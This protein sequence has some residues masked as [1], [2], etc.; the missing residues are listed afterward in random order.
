MAITGK[1]HHTMNSNFRSF[2]IELKTHRVLRVWIAFYGIVVCAFFRV[3]QN[4]LEFF[5]EFD[6]FINVL[7]L[8]FSDK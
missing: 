8:F 7:S 1:I 3:I 6:V 4:A 5:G 2:F